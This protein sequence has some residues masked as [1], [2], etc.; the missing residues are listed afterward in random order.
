MSDTVGFGVVGLGAIANVHMGAIERTDGARLVG[1]AGRNADRT[2]SVA[3]EW[4]CNAF[5]DVQA[6]AEDD[7]VDVI[8]ICTPSGAHLEPA[9]AA[10]AAGKHL[11]VEKPLEVTVERCDRMIDACQEAGV[12][13]AG[14]FQARFAESS[15]LLR[16]A[17]EAG[18]FGR[19]VHGAAYVNWW[20]SQEYYDQADWRGTWA[21]DGGGAVMNQAIHQLDLLQWL[22]GDVESVF[23]FTDCLA[24]ERL[25][26]EDTA[27]AVLRFANGAVGVIEAM[28]ST[29]PGYPK[30]LEIHGNRGGAIVEDNALTAWHGM[31]IP[32]TETAEVLARFAGK[33][34]AGASADPMALSHSGHTAQIADLV[35][36]VQHG[37]PPTISGREA[38]KAVALTEALY[39]SARSGRPETV[40]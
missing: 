37:E 14:V 2:A 36:A 12:H 39:R 35:R 5:A 17:I 11:L 4:N 34:V 25:E 15:Q 13:L 32:E 20:R 29:F 7:A 30:R 1:V 27:V 26:V 24:H 16:T 8:V 31:D 18:R 28:T 33:E 10:A 3:A 21:L 40:A 9:L 19:L 6:L 23:A 38:R 22:M